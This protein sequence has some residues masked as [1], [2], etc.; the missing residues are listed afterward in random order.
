MGASENDRSRPVNS[1]WAG[2]GPV[3]RILHALLAGGGIG[4]LLALAGVGLAVA[5]AP[6]APAHS[7]R[8]FGGGSGI[9][10]DDPHGFGGGGGGATVTAIGNGSI[11]VSNRSTKSTT[12]LTTSSTT[13]TVDGTPAT[14]SD[15]AIGDSVNVRLPFTPHS[16]ATSGGTTTTTTAPA[17][18]TALAINVVLPELGGR[19]DAVNGSTI[20]L[21]DAQGFWRTVDTTGSTLYLKS[22]QNTQA[23]AVNVGSDVTAIGT[24]DSDHTDLDASRINVILPTVG[25]KV[26]GVSGP[27]ITISSFSGTSQVINTQSSTVFTS[28][29]SA[30][31]LGDVKVGDFIS[32]TGTK[33]SDGSVEAVKVEIGGSGAGGTGRVPGIHGRQGV[34]ERSTTSTT[35]S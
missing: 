24:I 35:A 9:A 3:P 14:P 29:K 11:T 8:G 28:G 31:S 5:A 17:T 10:L 27:A 4:A 20:T 15:V 22:G 33:G 19:V 16:W 18:P 30:G 13:Y 2:R 12:Y 23:S 1:D 25:G 7:H 21:V 34:G 32:A 6:S 26:T